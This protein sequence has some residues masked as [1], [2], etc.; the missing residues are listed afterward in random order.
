M[1]RI[2]VL[3]RRDALILPIVFLSLVSL[4]PGNFLFLIYIVHVSLMIFVMNEIF[5]VGFTL[6]IQA[7]KKF[8]ESKMGYKIKFALNTFSR[9]Q[10]LFQSQM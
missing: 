4:L 2:I 8:F 5:F 1:K 10:K 3:L 7:L 9:S 6:K